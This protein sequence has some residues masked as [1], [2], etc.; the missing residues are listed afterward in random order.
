[1]KF[2][3][4]SASGDYYVECILSSIKKAPV[5]WNIKKQVREITNAPRQQ[6]ITSL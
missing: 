5:M 1:M 3:A 2:A 6:K 4:S